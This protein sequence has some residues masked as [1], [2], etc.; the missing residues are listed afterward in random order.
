MLSQTDQPGARPDEAAFKLP[1]QALTSKSPTYSLMKFLML[2]RI[3]DCFLLEAF[4]DADV[5]TFPFVA[6]LD[7]PAA[8]GSVT[9]LLVGCRISQR[10]L[11]IIRYG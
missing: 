4:D 10:S 2:I 11:R 6:G 5:L 9:V 8:F 1:F 7:L 3:A